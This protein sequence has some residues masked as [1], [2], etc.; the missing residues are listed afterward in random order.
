MEDEIDMNDVK[1]VE[2]ISKYPEPLRF[3]VVFADGESFVTRSSNKAWA[4]SDAR[5]M[6]MKREYKD[7]LLNRLAK[8]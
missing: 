7:E 2:V 3:R 4:I 6:K 5:A 1:S 8:G